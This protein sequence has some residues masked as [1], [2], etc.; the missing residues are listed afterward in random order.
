MGKNK[1][2]LDTASDSSQLP[3]SRRK[4]AKFLKQSE[5]T[6]KSEK[7]NPEKTKR[8]TLDTVD[9]AA[10][11][12]TPNSKT[13]TTQPAN[14]PTSSTTV[15]AVVGEVV[16]AV[17]TSANTAKTGG[18][19]ADVKVTE[20]PTF[21]EV[22]N[23]ANNTGTGTTTLIPEKIEKAKDN[24][25]I[26][27]NNVN[28]G[29]STDGPND[30]DIAINT[31]TAGTTVT[32]E[33]SAPTISEPTPDPD[34]PTYLSTQW[35]LLYQAS[36]SYSVKD[37]SAT[38][39]F[40]AVRMM[41]AGGSKSKIFIEYYKYNTGG[42]IVEKCNE[43]CW[44]EQLCTISNLVIN[45]LA[46]CLNS[47]GKDGFYEVHKTS[48]STLTTQPAPTTSK[49]KLFGEG[50]DD[51]DH[52]DHGEIDDSHDHSDDGKADHDHI[53]HAEPEKDV[54]R[55]KLEDTTSDI[56]SKAVAILD[57]DVRGQDG[58]WSQRP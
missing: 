10:D 14:T 18:E 54:S 52:G 58:W 21:A 12:S 30:N 57:Q 28:N 46:T 11:A 35:T 36:K 1:A 23:K 16:P 50:D 7:D 32:T 22:D 56:S 17:P 45:E 26:G 41:V 47:T 44:R 24:A 37:L 55:E 34:Y 13:T 20:V 48:T 40:S 29:T 3:K 9:P 42:H 15:Q 53:D 5:N 39:M 25:T 8:E 43:T 2:L 38:S 51:P 49:K 4:N 31:N 19:D 6:E 33:N 27:E